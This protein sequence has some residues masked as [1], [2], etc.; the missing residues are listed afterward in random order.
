[1]M[2]EMD[3]NR[4]VYG[5]YEGQQQPIPPY[6][7]Y[8]Q[9]P[10]A[11]VIDD[12][13]IE[14]ISQRVAQ[15]MAQQSQPSGGKVYGQRRSSMLPAGLRGAIAIVSVIAFIPLGI[16]LGYFGQLVALGILGAVILGV[17]AITNGLLS[18]RD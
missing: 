5:A 17:N 13:L 4:P 16:V 9:P 15:Q 3:A 10:V 6:G 7:G 14:A 2:S 11:G 8:Q 1:M 18:P 12:N